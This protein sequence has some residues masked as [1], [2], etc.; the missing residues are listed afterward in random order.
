MNKNDSD[1]FKSVIKESTTGDIAGRDLYKTSN[2]EKLLSNIEKKIL[3]ILYREYQDRGKNGFK[4]RNTH[5]ELE[6]DDGFDLTCVNDSEYI[7]TE[8]DFY[9]M[10]PHGIRYMDNLTP[11]DLSQ[12]MLPKEEG[13]REF[14]MRQQRQ[15]F[16][17]NRANFKKNSSR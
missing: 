15:R 10:T 1:S 12:I 17:Q 14:I 4:I 11:I 16:E 3:K 13:E 9:K 2:T 7:K 5:S 6:I 8:G